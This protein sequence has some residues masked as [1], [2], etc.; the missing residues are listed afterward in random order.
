MENTGC[1]HLNVVFTPITGAED[2]F[3]SQWLCR[4]CLVPF[5]PIAKAIPARP[6]QK[7][8]CQPLDDTVEELIGTP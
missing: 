7:F 4:D 3:I 5:A 8:T 2:Q 1:A 6:S